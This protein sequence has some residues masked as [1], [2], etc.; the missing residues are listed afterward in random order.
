M[1]ARARMWRWLA[2]TAIAFGLFW[3]LPGLAS[4]DQIGVAAHA[5]H[6][7]AGFAL[8]A[9]FIV[10]GLLFGPDAAPG[11]VDAV[12]SARARGLSV[13]RVADRADEPARHAGADRL[14]RAHG[15]GGR[16]RVARR[17][18]SRRGA[19]RRRA[20]RAD[21]P[22]I[23]GQC[24]ASNSSC[25]RPARSPAQCRSRSACS[26]ER[27]LRWAPGLRRCSAPPASSRRAARRSA[28]RA[29]AVGGVR[30]V[31]AARDPGRALLSHLPVRAVAAVRR[32]CA[33]C[34]PR[35]SRSRPKR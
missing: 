7:V 30:G 34:S 24:R 6:V 32:A 25:C 1:L 9:T 26:T 31:R 2:F 23:L 3:T 10:S 22:A 8:V 13:R 33:C 35:C 27:T 20:G 16:D 4:L 15:G 12:S 28:D 17:S 29:D 5:F 21:V 14:R 11:R 19:A 18:R